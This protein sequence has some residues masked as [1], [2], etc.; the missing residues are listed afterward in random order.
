M[1]ESSGDQSRTVLSHWDSAESLGQC[2]HWDSAVTGTVL[3]HWDSA[4]SLGQ[5]C[6]LDSVFTKTAT[7]RQVFFN[8]SIFLQKTCKSDV[9]NFKNK[10][11]LLFSLNVKLLL[12][13]F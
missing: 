9:L 7:I 12:R 1:T 10:F 5:C 13:C 11:E 8:T 4:E 6:H 2:C 3:S